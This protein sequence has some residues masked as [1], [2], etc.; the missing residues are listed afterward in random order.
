[1]KDQPT[2]PSILSTSVQ[3]VVS[4]GVDMFADELEQQGASVTRVA[5]RPPV[6]IAENAYRLLGAL[7]D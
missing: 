4:L 5:W 3:H 2:A 6:E 7:E 1:M